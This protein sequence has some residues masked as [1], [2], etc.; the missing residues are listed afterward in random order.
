MQLPSGKLRIITP[1]SQCF[2]NVLSIQIISVS[3]QLP[4]IKM[5]HTVGILGV[6]GNVG[7]PTVQR[8]IGEAKEGK[9]KLVIFHRAS[10]NL[11]GLSIDG[12]NVEL[13]TLDYEDSVENIS[14]AVRGIH[15]LM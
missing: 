4:N 11:S 8:L 1:G 9:I 5:V 3:L 6:T 13:R 15:V 14:K 2:S 7:A 10:T 12:N